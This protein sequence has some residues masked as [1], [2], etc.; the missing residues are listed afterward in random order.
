M[1]ENTTKPKTK[2]KRRT[3]KK[4]TKKTTKK[5]VE[6]EP[7]VEAEP[8][9]V[10]EEVD[11]NLV[12]LESVLRPGRYLDVAED[13]KCVL[14]TDPAPQWRRKEVDGYLALESLKFPGS[15]LDAGYFSPYV[16]PKSEVGAYRNWKLLELGD[17]VVR[18]GSVVHSNRHLTVDRSDSLVTSREVESKNSHWR[19]S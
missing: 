19:L 8:E 5:T 7:V 2:R 11:P 3:R 14:G 13:R 12:S 1:S 9:P 15:H 4:T 16:P 18:L 6:P 10:V 17:G